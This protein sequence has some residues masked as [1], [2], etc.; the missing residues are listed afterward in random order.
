MSF[1][2]VLKPVLVSVG[3]LLVAFF[4]YFLSGAKGSTQV[5]RQ[6]EQVKPDT[7]SNMSKSLQFLASYTISTG[8]DSLA[9]NVGLSKDDIDYI[10]GGSIQG[11]QSGGGIGQISMDV[12]QDIEALRQMILDAQGSDPGSTQSCNNV[13]KI[14][15]PNTSNTYSSLM[16]WT[17]ASKG[18]IEAMNADAMGSVQVEV[19]QW[20]NPGTDDLTKVSKTININCC[21]T[22]HPIVKQ[23]FAEIYAD[24]SQ[25]VITCAGGYNV[26]PMNNSSSTSSTSTHSY[27]GT[28]D[29]NYNKQQG[30]RVEWNWNSNNGSAEKPYPRSKEEWDSLPEGQYKYECIYEGCPIVQYFEKYGLRWGGSWSIGYCDPMH[31]SIFDH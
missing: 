25:P 31:F 13:F 16:P 10:T 15:Y 27:G 24:S 21:K 3:I 14:L 7:A 23:I 8:D 22:L 28:I 19:W 17:S 1:R 4:I 5:Y 29:I 20:A 2:S 12:P 30:G 26:R 9:I 11:S 18:T 6:Y